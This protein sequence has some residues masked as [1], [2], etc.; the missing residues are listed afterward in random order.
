MTNEEAIH[1]LEYSKMA[2]H[3][4]IDEGVDNGRFVGDGVE[5]EWKSDTPLNKAYNDMIEALDLAIKALEQTRWISVSEPPKEDGK[6][7]VSRKN[8]ENIWVEEAYYSTTSRT[9]FPKGF[10]IIKDNFSWRIN[11]VI[12]WMPLP[13]PYTESE[14]KG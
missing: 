10:S 14:E 12:A 8:E 5:G 7:L 6:Y 13:E 2:Y 1:K 9:T 4:L 11:N 3:K